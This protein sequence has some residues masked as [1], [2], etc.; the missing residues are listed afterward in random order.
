MRRGEEGKKARQNL[1]KEKGRW[2]EGRVGGKDLGKQDWSI[3]SCG[4]QQSQLRSIC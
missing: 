3:S 4:G 2:E 1:G